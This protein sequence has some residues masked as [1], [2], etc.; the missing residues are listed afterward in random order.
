MTQEKIPPIL[1]DEDIVINGLTDADVKFYQQV[2]E[3]A[4]KEGMREVVEWIETKLLISI[5]TTAISGFY[6]YQIYQ[7]DLEKYI[8]EKGL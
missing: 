1:N 6:F 5:G 2:I 4:R 7:D 8:K 3:Q